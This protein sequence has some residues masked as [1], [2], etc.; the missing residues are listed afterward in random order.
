MTNW[1]L[2]A[3]IVSAIGAFGTIVG[4]CMRIISSIMSVQKMVDSKMGIEEHAQ[5][6]KDRDQAFGKTLDSIKNSIEGL[7]K[8]DTLDD[9]KTTLTKHIER[10]TEIDERKEQALHDIKDAVSILSKEVAVVTT[11]VNMM[12]DP[13]NV[14][15]VR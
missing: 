3:M 6:C 1:Q 12:K 5:I 9:I 7:V 4:L 13:T 2:V 15:L 11:T 10:Q 8:K 14:R